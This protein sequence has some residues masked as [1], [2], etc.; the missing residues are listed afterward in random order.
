MKS[1]LIISQRYYNSSHQSLETYVQLNTKVSS[2]LQQIKYLLT[3][4]KKTLLLLM[5][6]N[7]T[8]P[9]GCFLTVHLVYIA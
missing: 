8:V 9:Q 1:K 3:Q 2:H 5:T 7:N 6:N 4:K